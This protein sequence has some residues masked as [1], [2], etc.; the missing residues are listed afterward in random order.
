MRLIPVL[1]TA[2]VLLFVVACGPADTSLDFGSVV[3]AP[4]EPLVIGVSV[5]RTGDTTGDAGRIERGVRLS[6]E[7]QGAIKGH[8]LV[9]DV[10]ADGC[11]AEQSVAVAETFVAMGDVLGVVVPMCSPGCVSAS[12]VYD[13]AHTLMVTPSC[14]AS[15][16]TNQGLET[17][18]RIAWNDELGA[19]GGARFAARELKAKRVYAVNDGTF[20]GKTQRDAF[21]VTLKER[22]GRLIADETINAAE[23][24][25]TALVADIRAAE[26]D[27][28]FFG[29]FLPAARFLV[30]QLRYAGVTAPFM[31]GDALWDAEGFVATANGA[32]EGAYV[33][34]AGPLRDTPSDDFSRRYRERWGED[35]GP[36]SALGYDAAHLILRAAE[37]TARTRDGGVLIDR[38]S[39]RDKVLQSDY[40][41]ATGRLRFFPSGERRGS[42][43]AVVRRVENG[44]FVVVTEFE[45]K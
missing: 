12:L 14:T 1:A 9:V 33:T 7:E 35:P 28:V 20:Y 5:A 10:R 30:Q 11:T 32:A 29:G 45:A 31:G 27:M 23:W 15:V 18:F 41:A 21:K 25:F 22:G 39:L 4:G 34:D 42:A 36:F 38:R 43:S 13:D 3:T 37:K 2:T 24:D 17:V 44:A 8:L 16:L 19:I 26:P 40:T 6:V